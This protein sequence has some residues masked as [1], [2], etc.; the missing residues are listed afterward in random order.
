MRFI[1]DVLLLSL[2]TRSADR[3][4]TP[5]CSSLLFA[6]WLWH[7][8]YHHKVRSPTSVWT[9]FNAAFH[10]ETRRIGE[11]REWKDGIRDVKHAAPDSDTFIHSAV[12]PRTTRWRGAGFT[13]PFVLS[14]LRWSSLP[15]W[16]HVQAYRLTFYTPSPSFCVSCKQA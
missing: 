2:K 7:L 6:H 1:S 3:K 13:V 10:G 15:L 16:L 9:V 12:F 4:I 11:W 14:P 8:S 5:L